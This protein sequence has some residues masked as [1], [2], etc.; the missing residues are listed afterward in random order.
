MHFC[1]R[2]VLNSR[3]HSREHFD[4][5]LLQVKLGSESLNLGDVFILDVGEKIF[6]WMPPESGRLE[7]IKVYCNELPWI[8]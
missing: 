5:T 4:H 2:R 1:C 7:K 6:V 8:R 3:N